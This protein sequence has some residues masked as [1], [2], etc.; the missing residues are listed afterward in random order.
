[1]IH[2]MLKLHVGNFKDVGGLI[3]QQGLSPKSIISFA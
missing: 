3:N 1:M 2:N